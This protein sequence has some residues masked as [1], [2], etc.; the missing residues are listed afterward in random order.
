[1]GPDPGAKRGE[2]CIGFRHLK[3]DHLC[4][5]DGGGGVPLDLCPDPHALGRLGHGLEADLQPQLDSDHVDGSP[6][7][8]PDGDGACEVLGKVG[9]FPLLPT[10]L[11]KDHRSVHDDVGG[12]DPACQSRS[13]HEGFEGGTGLPHGLSRPVE[14]GVS[15]VTPPDHGPN[16]A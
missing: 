1:M 5:A 14:L 12:G 6:K 9:R 13:V 8:L 11:G 2:A 7:P 15:E 10:D 4:G 16:G 3:G